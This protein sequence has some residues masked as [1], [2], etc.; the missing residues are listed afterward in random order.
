M[1][2]QVLKAKLR[3]LGLRLEWHNRKD[4]SGKPILAEWQAFVF[5]D[6]CMFQVCV[7]CPAKLNLPVPH[8]KFVPDGKWEICLGD[9]YWS[10][11][12]ERYFD[13]AGE[14]MKA[15]EQILGKFGSLLEGRLK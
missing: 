4:F 15:V 5:E 2:E 9:Y 14:G 8:H 1:N 13:K 10:R 11:D 6:I 3:S 12:K 7:R